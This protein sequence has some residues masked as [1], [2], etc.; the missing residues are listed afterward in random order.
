MTS[1]ITASPSENNSRGG[2]QHRRH[3]QRQH[4]DA[5]GADPHGNARDH[6]QPGQ[7]R[8]RHAA[9]RSDDIDGNTGPPRTALIDSP[10]ARHLHSSSTSSAPTE[11][12]ALF[13]SNGLIASCPGEEHVRRVVPGRRGVEGRQTRHREPDHRADDQPAAPDPG[14]QQEREPPHSQADRG[15]EQPDEQGVAELRDV[16]VAERGKPGQLQRHRPEARQ[17][18]E[19]DED[20]GSDTR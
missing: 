11:Y 2:Q 15:G 12:C 18:V 8:H 10:Y 17:G 6:R 7:M 16:R 4:D 3:G 14:T 1:G 9:R 19:P 5:P 13:C 20:Q